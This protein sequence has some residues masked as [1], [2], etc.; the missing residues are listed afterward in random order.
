M[1][2]ELK[3]DGIRDAQS[4]IFSKDGK[5]IYFVGNERGYYDVFQYDRFSGH[6][7]NLTQDEFHDRNPRLSPDGKE[8]LYSSRREG[9]Y[10]IYTVVIDT[11]EKTQLTSGLGN[12]IQA[13]FSQDMNS[14]YFSSDR[15]D[16]IYN[17]YELELDTGLKKQYTNIL[18]GAFSPQERVFFDHKEGE[19]RRQ[20]IFTAYYQ[21][22]YRVYRMDKPEQREE[23]YDVARDN[24]AN[25]KHFRL[26]NNIKLNPDRHKPYK[27]SKNFSFS[28]ADVTAGVTDDGRFQSNTAIQFSDTL[29]NHV[30]DIN[31]Y[32][33]SSYEN[34]YVGYLNQANRLQW[35]AVANSTQ[36]FFLYATVTPS[37][38]AL[39]I[40]RTRTYKR[41]ELAGFVRYPFNFYT[42]IDAGLG[43]TDRDQFTYEPSAI[44]PFSYNLLPDR[45]HR[46]VR[47]PLVFSRFGSVQELWPAAGHALRFALQLHSRPGPDVQY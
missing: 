34:Y 19:E 43:L 13:S 47:L 7:K 12:D 26:D 35:G 3:F 37:G 1:V 5:K 21:G 46:T 25:V 18:T 28:G 41:N 6:I 40:D 10:K 2:E 36:S 20:L 27:I 42:R 45:F 15:F 17:I 4:P 38:D 32:T 22:R 33:I 29:G 30:L 24:Y 14:I 31:T 44:Q 11:L 16:D 9:F 8:L 39:N 23:V